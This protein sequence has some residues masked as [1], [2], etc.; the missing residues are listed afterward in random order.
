MKNN[1]NS[2][3]QDFEELLK[4]KMDSLSSSVDCFDKISAR[5]FPEK[6]ADFS[7]SEYTV[8]DL[9]NVSGKRSIAPAFR[10]GATAAAILI[11]AGILPKTAL[12]NLTKEKGPASYHKDYDGIVADILEET[13]DLSDYVYYD[14]ELNSYIQNDIYISP[15]FSCP[16]APQKDSDIRVRLF[17]KTCK[18]FATNQVFAVEY[19][20]TYSVENFIAVAD[21]G[22]RLNYDEISE[23]EPFIFGTDDDLCAAAAE[24]NLYNKYSSLY[25]KNGDKVSAVSYETRSLYKDEN[26]ITPITSY[27]FCCESAGHQISYDVTSLCRLDNGGG[28]AETKT[29]ETT[30]GQDSWAAS[31]Y[32]D[33]TSARPRE[34]APS[35]HREEFFREHPAEFFYSDICYYKKELSGS[36]L[37]S[38]SINRQNIIELIYGK[39]TGPSY[40]YNV[41]ASV[42]N[43]SAFSTNVQIFVSADIKEAI[44]IGTIGSQ[45]SD[46]LAIKQLTTDTQYSLSS[47]S[48]K[49]PPLYASLI[50]LASSIRELERSIAHDDLEEEAKLQLQQELDRLYSKKEFLDTLDKS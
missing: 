18:D 47:Y 44:S 13:A 11:L 41:L 20:D 21:S 26:G 39:Y 25:D 42:R 9:E 37:T 6:N 10:W 4:S 5:A 29:F 38:N 12:V 22:V 2:G 48:L 36:K 28:T 40:N 34:E 17:V 7:D 23:A 8:S 32:S 30:A 45:K 27:L 43:Y 49:S 50:S 15:L 3:N 31:L 46:Y 35:L 16:F 19:R 1:D 14:M 33:N 24:I